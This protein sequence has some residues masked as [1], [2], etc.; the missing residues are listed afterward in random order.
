[1]SKRL[2]MPL[3]VGD[4]TADTM[5]LGPT[6]LGIY[7]RLILHCWQ[8]GTIPRDDRKLATISHCD[9]RLWHR[10]RETVLQFFDPVD[11]ST[12][13]QKRVTREL[14]RAIEISNKRK[15]AAEQKQSKSSP[16]AE[17]KHPQSQSQSQSPIAAAAAGAA[18]SVP[19]SGQPKKK[20]EWQEGYELAKEIASIVG[21]ADDFEIG[22]WGGATYRAQQW[23]SQGWQKD[24][25]LSA[26]RDRM[27]RRGGAPSPS[28]IQYFEPAIAEHIA[29]QNAPLPVIVEFPAKTIGVTHGK[30]ARPDTREPYQKRRDNWFDALDEF[31]AGVAALE[32]SDETGGEGGGEIV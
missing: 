13:H 1:M 20:W 7:M 8:H 26:I 10:Y 21:R 28:N 23:L 2:W 14:Q 16:K 30:A 11:A 24:L 19:V 29:R 18:G 27:R 9:S 6:E 32:Q 12:M 15:A 4:F 31:K 5:H 22:G 17:Q 3:Y 25:I